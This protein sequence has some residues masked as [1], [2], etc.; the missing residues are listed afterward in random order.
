MRP[1]P[2]VKVVAVCTVPPTHRLHL[3]VCSARRSL[4]ACS[5]AGVQLD[6][7]LIHAL[8]VV[9]AVPVVLVAVV[10]CVVADVVESAYCSVN[11][12]E[13]RPPFC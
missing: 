6:A 3:K 1:T 10:V 4:C 2:V 8:V 11:P 5:G 9:V 7:D 13:G 12:T